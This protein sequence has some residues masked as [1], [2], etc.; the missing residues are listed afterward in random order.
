[1]T[2]D[3]MNYLSETNLIKM[4]QTA[5]CL[6]KLRNTLTL[7]LIFLTNNLFSKRSIPPVDTLDI[8]RA[9]HRLLMAYCTVNWSSNFFT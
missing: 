8:S 9:I 5:V 1:M 7:F 3:N 2:I 6:N 4:E